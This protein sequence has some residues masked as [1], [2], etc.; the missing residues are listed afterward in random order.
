MECLISKNDKFIA[1]FSVLMMY[2]AQIAT[3]LFEKPI[4]NRNSRLTALQ[5]RTFKI[6]AQVS[7]GSGEGPT[8][9]LEDGVPYCFLLRYGSPAAMALATSAQTCRLAGG[10]QPQDADLSVCKG[11]GDTGVI[12]GVIGGSSGPP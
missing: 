9:H 5:A 10:T 7:L 3:F 11:C 1:I 6:K 8:R 2:R 12:G 4:N